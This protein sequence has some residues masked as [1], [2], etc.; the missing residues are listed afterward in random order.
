MPDVTVEPTPQRIFRSA[1]LTVATLLLAL[2]AYD[3]SFELLN[4]IM[5]GL[6]LPEA[7]VA[8]LEPFRIANQYGLFAVMT[9]GRYEIEFQG[10][11]D[12]QNWIVYPF[13]YKPQVLKERPGLYAPYQPRFDWNL[14]FASL[15]NWQQNDIVPLT[16]ERLLSND[17]DVLHLFR[18]N[19]FPST[20]PKYVRAVL[21][22][23]WFTTLAEKRSTGNW[24]RRSLLGLYAP[25]LT[26]APGG[27]FAIV[28]MP[29]PLPPHD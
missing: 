29:D 11:N 15:G 5:P 12:G 9:G 22:Q 28:T 8:A 18:A 19:P 16:E 7:P 2:I 3:T 17:P 14:W 4:I 10:S 6:P 1:K 24:W 25:E 27:H 13:R 20:P 23:Y 21:W 26:P